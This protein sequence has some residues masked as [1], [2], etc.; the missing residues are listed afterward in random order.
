MR[1]LDLHLINCVVELDSK[2]SKNCVLIVDD[3]HILGASFVI[4]ST[5][6]YAPVATFSVN[7]NIKFL[8]NIKQGFER[9]IS[10]I[11][12]RSQITAQPK[13]NDLDY[14]VDPTFRNIN[15]FLVF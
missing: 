8:E 10:W 7:D 9:T 15:R 5:K 13:K 12:Y 1:T 6:L 14:L 2:W 11:K 4:A 3:D